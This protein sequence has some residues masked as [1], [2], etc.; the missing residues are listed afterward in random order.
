M[1]MKQILDGAK[2]LLGRSAEG[3]QSMKCLPCMRVCG[4]IRDLIQ[5]RL[6]P[7]WCIPIHIALSFAVAI[8]THRY[9]E[10]PI[11]KL[12]RPK[13]PDAPES[14]NQTASSSRILETL[15]A[16]GGYGTFPD[17]REA[18]QK[19]EG[20]ST[21][22]PDELDFEVQSMP[23]NNRVHWAQDVEERVEEIGHRKS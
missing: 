5:V 22:N 17:K 2:Y 16:W 15:V 6:L 1:S 8:V 20:L 10:E 9:V 23:R 12:L 13:P 18:T 19:Y 3:M 14:S 11:R 21:E 4:L 7:V